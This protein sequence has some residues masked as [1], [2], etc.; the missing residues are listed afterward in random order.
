MIVKEEKGIY[1][2]RMQP[3]DEAMSSL[4]KLVKDLGLHS[5]V[6][7]SGIGAFKRC[8]IGVFIGNGQYGRMT[9]EEQTEVLSFLGNVCIHE[10]EPFPHIHVALSKEDFSMIGGHLFEGEVFPTLELFLRRP[11]EM[12]FARQFEAETGLSSLYFR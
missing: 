4:K 10:G 11:D 2:V 1:A 6:V 12:T 5:L 8:Q 9:I 7:V 3:G